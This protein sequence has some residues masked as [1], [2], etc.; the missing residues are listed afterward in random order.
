[1]QSSVDRIAKR[2]RIKDLSNKAE[3]VFQYIGPQ[4]MIFRLIN[5]GNELASEINHA[6]AY[7]TSFAQKGYMYDNGSRAVIN[8]IYRLVGGL[9]CDIDIIHAAGGAQII[10]EPFESIDSCYGIEY[11]TLLREAL[12]KGMPD[13]YRGPQQNPY[14]VKLVRPAVSYGGKPYRDSYDDDFF[15]NFVRQE[16]PR[17]RKIIFRC[18]KSDLDAIKRY[19]DIIEVKYHEEEQHHA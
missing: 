11:S 7:F 18:T 10:P 12:L 17:D 13:N 9:M 4:N 19:A 2:E 3:G 8:R 5:A 15:D 6:V 1:M 14:V 16:E